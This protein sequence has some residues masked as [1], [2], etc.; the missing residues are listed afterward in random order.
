MRYLAAFSTVH[1]PQYFKQVL[2][3]VSTKQTTFSWAKEV[4]DRS[5][6]MN[7]I[8]KPI[9]MIATTDRKAVDETF[10]VDKEVD[11]VPR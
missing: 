10:R 1:Y 11:L 9:C 5:V 3:S 7:Y 2:D 4:V 6:E 8:N